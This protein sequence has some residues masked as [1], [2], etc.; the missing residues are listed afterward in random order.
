MASKYRARGAYHFAEYKDPKSIYRKHALCVLQE[1]GQFSHQI[2]YAI[3]I[4]SGEGLFCWLLGREGIQVVGWEIDKEALR[5][6]KD[7]PCMVMN[8][9]LAQMP[10]NIQA[11]LVLALDVLEHIPEDKRTDVIF[12]MARTAPCAFVAIPDRPD[13]HAV[14]EIP[15][16]AWVILNMHQ[17][18]MPLIWRDRRHARHIMLFERSMP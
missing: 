13:E 6:S 8:R 7:K 12:E 1:L 4:G 11:D 3:D 10:W 5:L 9:D 2:K 16:P 17:A 15:D 18:Q 14:G